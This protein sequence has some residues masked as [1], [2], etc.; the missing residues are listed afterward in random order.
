MVEPS[1]Q[2]SKLL[3]TLLVI[4]IVFYVYLDVHLYLRIQNYP[5][6][7]NL[8]HN[9][10]QTTPTIIPDTSPGPSLPVVVNYSDVT[11][12]NCHINPLCDVTVKALMLDHTNHYIFAPMATVFDDFVGFSRSNLITPNM[13]SFFHVFVALISGR[14]IASDS[15]GYRR[16]GVVLFQVRTFLD[17][18]DGHVA[19]AKRN[20][21]GERSEI[22]T[23]GYY[24][25][26]IC[27]GL[28]CIALMIGVF[29]FL[30]NNVSCDCA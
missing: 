8:H 26:G 14:M 22:G 28:G 15:L 17:D 6:D 3:L 5:I 9:G 19:R 16:V 11:W 24:V 30:K 21:R 7:R 23:M 10:T 12:V 20:I 4:L 1:S 13:I 25:D 29:V 18:L 2:I 27:D